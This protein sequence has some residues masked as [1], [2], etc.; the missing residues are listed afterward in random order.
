MSALI[1]ASNPVGLS[2]H[3]SL[4]VQGIPVEDRAEE[5]LCCFFEREDV[6]S[7]ALILTADEARAVY[8]FNRTVQR[9]P[10]G[11]YSICLPRKQ[12]TPKLGVS[13]SV[14]IK[15]FSSNC[16]SLKHKGT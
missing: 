4:G 11:H 15:R 14:A 16:R 12:P 2:R 6:P 5:V 9:A 13:K 7:S 3:F 1:A 10:D 8:H